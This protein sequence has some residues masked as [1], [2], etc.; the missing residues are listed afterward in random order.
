MKTL[1]ALFG[2]PQTV[3]LAEPSGGPLGTISQKE[4]S[5][6]GNFDGTPKFLQEL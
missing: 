2:F 3:T 1:E 5:S 6:L 4:I